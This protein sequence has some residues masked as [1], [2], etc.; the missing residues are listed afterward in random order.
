MGRS[1]RTDRVPGHEAHVAVQGAR[2]ADAEDVAAIYN[3]GIAE[4]QATFETR[5]RTGADILEWLEAGERFP[6]LVATRDGAVAGWARIGRY[7]QRE[8]Y[9]GV[10]ECQIYVHHGHRR[11]GVGARLAK[12]IAGEAER[13]GYWKL[14]GRLFT[15]NEASIGLIRRCGFT[16]VGVH[17]RHGALDGVWKDVLVVELLLGR[18]D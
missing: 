9:R 1:V 10:G 17:R 14:I 18:R 3:Q 12:A 7:S 2:P 4:R 15:T 6:L 5:S 13:L 8:A 16:E 11:Q